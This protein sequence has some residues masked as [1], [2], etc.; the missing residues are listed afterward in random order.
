LPADR[1][2]KRPAV[3]WSRDFSAALKIA[4]IQVKAA[5]IRGMSGIML[6]AWSRRPTAEPATARSEPDPAIFAP[7]RKC[8]KHE[9]L[10]VGI[11]VIEQAK[12][13]AQVLVPLVKALRN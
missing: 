4:I 9:R 6:F 13:Q 10:S 11:S 3:H 1:N 8:S 2:G 5:F 7:N 12:I